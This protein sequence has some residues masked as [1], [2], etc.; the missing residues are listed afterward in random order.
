[1]T[2][3]HE[4][5]NGKP[6][7]KDGRG[8]RVANE[9]RM[10]IR[11]SFM[12]LVRSGE[13]GRS[14]SASAIERNIIQENPDL[15]DSLPSRQS[16]NAI[17]KPLRDNLSENKPLDSPWSLNLWMREPHNIAKEDLPIILEVQAD[18]EF[19]RKERLSVREARWVVPI[20]QILSHQQDTEDA[21]E[22][23]DYSDNL[24]DEV[25]RYALRERVIELLE[26]F[27]QY[28]SYDLDINLA[29]FGRNLSAPHEIRNAED[30]LS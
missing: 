8:R 18:I 4:N 12:R 23:Q 6:L 28:D 3:N 21:T 1:M 25:K 29:V 7:E 20:K 5:N 13:T 19:N 26:K 9:V 16:I 30:D 22:F 14:L 10:E 11:N 27:G 15:A 17:V 24:T 2:G